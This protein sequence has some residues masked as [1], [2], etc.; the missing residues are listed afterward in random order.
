MKSV[1][2]FFSILGVLVSLQLHAAVL[3]SNN[4]TISI[5]APG[6]GSSIVGKVDSS[7]LNRFFPGNN[8]IYVYQG[9]VTPG[10]LGSNVP[11]MAILPI[12]QDKC[13]FTY[14]TTNL[15]PGTYTLALTQQANLD[16][17]SS[18][19]SL[20]FVAV[21]NVNY[22]GSAATYN[23]PA[24][25]TLQVGAGKTYSKPSAAINASNNGDVIEIDPGTYSDDF[26]SISRSITLRGVGGA[27]PHIQRVSGTIP[28]GKGIY[29]TTAP[30]IAIEN[31]EI[32]GA[33]VPDENGA[34]VRIE[35]DTVICNS[36]LW[37]NENGVLGDGTNIRIEY[38]EFAYNGL[39]DVGYTHNM[40]VNATNFTLIYSYVHDAHDPNNS[41]DTGHNVKS[42]SRNN[43]ILY[44]RI[45]NE[46]VGTAS[47]QINLPQGGLT[48]IVGNVIRESPKSDSNRIILF[49]DSGR[50]GAANPSLTLYMVNNTI[51]SDDGEAYYT[52]GSGTT[53][54]I[55]NNLFW[56]TPKSV[57]GANQSNNIF[58]SDASIFVNKTNY[59]YHL[60]S[61][62]PA[63]NAGR[64]LSSIVGFSM[65]VDNE[66]VHPTNRKTR[67]LNGSIDAGAYEF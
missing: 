30:N 31:L 11:P 12:F 66:Y 60:N 28:N 64:E 19:E 65:K 39:T 35:N 56:G 38:S 24:K 46:D 58:S 25:R 7:L 36:Y 15:T 61:N 43:Y 51:I 4:T 23:F 47:D 53:S 49:Y 40:Y 44:N 59:D 63:I 6:S 33:R 27:R 52:P 62:A 22:S 18:V 8:A 2:I 14:Q 55:Y 45:A 9:A 54:Y 67:P 26:A 10:D 50:D 29:T 48:Y 57:S 32:S 37:N 42:R 21:T 34:A 17:P 16:K 20:V 13:N 3:K 1:Y 5:R 41:S